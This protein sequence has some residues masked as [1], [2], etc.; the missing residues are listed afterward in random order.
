MRRS[1][2]T[3]TF[4][5]DVK[6]VWDVVTNNE[7]YSWRSDLEKITVGED[8]LCFTEY[9]KG[10][11]RTDFM[12]TFRAPYT[13]YEFDMKSNN[14]TGHW[15]GIFSE[16]ESNGTQVDFTEE[17]YI[18]NRIMELLSYLFMNIRKIQAAYIADLRRKLQ[19]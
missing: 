7:D 15:T 13:R 3:A 19:E 10:G 8:G 1:K 6:T 18:N 16:T 4:Q 5:A 12:I 14:F 2:I 9:T 11:Y 17:L